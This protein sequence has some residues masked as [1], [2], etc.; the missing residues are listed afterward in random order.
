MH[1]QVKGEM[2]EFLIISKQ[3]SDHKQGHRVQGEWL[4]LQNKI[5]S[6]AAD[7]LLREGREVK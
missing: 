5:Q 4:S 2:L 1:F 3:A 7:I 6:W